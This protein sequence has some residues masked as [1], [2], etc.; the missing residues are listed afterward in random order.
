M[1]WCRNAEVFTECYSLKS[2]HANWVW[3][4]NANIDPA[5]PATHATEKSTATITGGGHLE[6]VDAIFTAIEATNPGVFVKANGS[7]A[8]AQ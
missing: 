2:A 1:G 6:T 8:I 4:N 7:L 3:G 5:D